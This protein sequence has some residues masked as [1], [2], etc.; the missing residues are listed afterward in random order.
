MFGSLLGGILLAAK[1][2]PKQNYEGVVIPIPCD[3]NSIW[4]TIPYL[5]MTSLASSEIRV[6]NAKSLVA[7]SLVRLMNSYCFPHSNFL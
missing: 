1:I 3:A 7:L 2:V 5:S 4:K 6:R